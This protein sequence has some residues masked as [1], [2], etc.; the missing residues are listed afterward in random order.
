M[1]VAPFVLALLISV[2]CGGESES[3]G[4]EA[5]SSSPSPSITVPPGAI[6]V[7]NSK[8]GPRT[9]TVARGTAVTWVNTT[10]TY[11]H[12]IV[13][14]DRL[15]NSHPNCTGVPTASVHSGCMQ[16][17]ETFTYTFAA[18][19]EFKYFCPIHGLCDGN[20]VCSGMYGIV[21]VT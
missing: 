1:R 12:M 20:K 11:A 14:V 6:V 7:A 2:A 3:P 15:F 9:V 10:G 13:S 4:A 19:G 18:S 16:I 5:T 8:F 17:G 21:T